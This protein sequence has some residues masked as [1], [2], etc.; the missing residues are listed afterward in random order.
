[1]HPLR[2]VKNRNFQPCLVE[3]HEEEAEVVRQTFQWLVEDGL[4]PRPMVQRLNA[5][6]IPPKQDCG[7]WQQSRVVDLLKHSAS[8]GTGY[9]HRYQTVPPTYS[10]RFAP[11]RKPLAFRERPQE[12]WVAV[13]AP[14]LI[15]AELFQRAQERLAENGRF[16][17]RHQRR[18]YLLSGLLQCA[19]CGYRLSGKAVRD[20]HSY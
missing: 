2:P 10:H 11:K 20:K 13:E 12:E 4:S 15:S 19:Q 14:A 6:K 5:R 16:A 3:I 7:G 8:M 9:F 17:W 1:M 18:G